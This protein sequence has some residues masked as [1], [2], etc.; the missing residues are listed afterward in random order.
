MH[1]M[2]DI[3]VMICFYLFSKANVKEFKG[4]INS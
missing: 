2:Q 1:K 4:R 3:L